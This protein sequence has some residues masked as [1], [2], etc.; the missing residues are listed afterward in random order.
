MPVARLSIDID[1]PPAALMRVICDFAAYPRFLPDMEEATVLRAEPA[2]WTVRYAVRIIR[3]VEY[4][5]DHVREGDTRLRWAL[6]E[7]AFKSNNGA[8]DL[9]PLDDGT[10]TRATYTLEID[11]GMFV[12][13][14]VVKTL[15]EQNLPATLAAF[16]Q[17][18]EAKG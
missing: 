4:T 18:A 13:G 15:L 3:R 2:R 6:V 1:V 8:W 16:K 7:G 11:L 12:P 14:S 5:L 10:R 17:R 9:E